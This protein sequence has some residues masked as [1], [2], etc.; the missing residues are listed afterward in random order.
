ML[1]WFHRLAPA[2]HGKPLVIFFTDSLMF[3][4]IFSE[5][6]VNRGTVS[7]RKHKRSIACCSRSPLASIR[8]A[9]KQCLPGGTHSLHRSANYLQP[10]PIA[11]QTGLVTF[12]DCKIKGFHLAM[13]ATDVWLLTGWSEVGFRLIQRLLK[14]NKQMSIS[15]K[16]LDL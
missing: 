15:L 3:D 12:S 5:D 16:W 2:T 1:R 4:S 11:W 9:I 6:Q 8:C 13:A 10:S 7:Y 14:A